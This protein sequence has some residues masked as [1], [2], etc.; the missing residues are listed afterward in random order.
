LSGK[1]IAYL[2]HKLAF[3][4]KINFEEVIKDLALVAVPIDN[5]ATILE[6]DTNTG[7]YSRVQESNL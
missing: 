2:K 6:G 3:Q 1:D 7:K 4:G 5:L